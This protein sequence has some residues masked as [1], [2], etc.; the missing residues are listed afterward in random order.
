MITSLNILIVDDHPMQVDSYISIINNTVEDYKF[1]FIKAFNCESAFKQIELN[2]KTKEMIDIALLDV[3]LPN[4][5]NTSY[6]KKI[7]FQ[8][9][10][11]GNADIITED[12]RLIERLFHQFKDIFSR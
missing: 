5:I 8:Q 12:L 11:I 2:Y 9:E 10:M 3:S 4:G 6:D 1:N 7:E